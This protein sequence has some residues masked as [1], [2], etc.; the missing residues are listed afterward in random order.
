MIPGWGGPTPIYDPEHDKVVGEGFYGAMNSL[1]RNCACGKKGE[2]APVKTVDD[3]D[4]ETGHISPRGAIS[5]ISH[6]PSGS[7]M[8]KV[9]PSG[10]PAAIDQS[11]L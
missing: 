7:T 9:E 6:G 2:D 5:P 11:D 4:A 3:A 10:A 1:K 8:V